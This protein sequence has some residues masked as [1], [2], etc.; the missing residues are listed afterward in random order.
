MSESLPS[1]D[2]VRAAMRPYGIHRAE[3]DRW[4][5]NVQA[6]AWD[7]GSRAKDRE[8]AETYDIVTPDEDRFL[9]INPY[10]VTRDG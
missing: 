9:A 4:L 3:F 6:W 2:Q 8:W 1:T 10:R 5:R 7:E